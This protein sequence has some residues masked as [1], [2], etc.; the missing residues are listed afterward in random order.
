MI[1]NQTRQPIYTRQNQ[2]VFSEVQ[3]AKAFYLGIL[4]EV[5]QFAILVILILKTT[6]TN[7][8]YKLTLDRKN[9]S[10]SRP[11][12]QMNICKIIFLLTTSS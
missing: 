9:F 3:S 5:K 11:K 6:S 8:Q 10:F 4:L 1:L 7:I 2:C 12:Y